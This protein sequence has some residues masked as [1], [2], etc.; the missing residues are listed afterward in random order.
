MGNISFK[1]FRR[2][3]TD[4]QFFNMLDSAIKTFCPDQFEVVMEDLDIEKKV[5]KNV[6]TIKPKDDSLEN[7]WQYKIDIFRYSSGKF[8]H[9]HMHCMQWGYWFTYNIDAFL[10]EKYGCILSDEGVTGTWKSTLGKYPTF[11][12]YFDK[13]YS[14]WG[15]K[16]ED[17][18]IKIKL[19][20]IELKHLPDYFKNIK[21][22]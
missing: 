14:R 12:S 8:G 5:T 17:K 9:K 4:Q 6:W 3:V 16:K 7:S 19:Y 20:E 21:G 18:E 11:K 15:S 13:Y 10:C 22:I 2:Q 1:S